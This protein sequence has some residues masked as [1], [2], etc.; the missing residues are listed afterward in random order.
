MDKIV[1]SVKN[2]SLARSSE[3][4]VP[5]KIVR[6]RELQK[7]MI[8]THISDPLM[9]GVAFWLVPSALDFL[10]SSRSHNISQILLFP[11]CITILAGDIRIPRLFCVIGRRDPIFW[12]TS[13][14]FQFVCLG[15]NS[16]SPMTTC[17]TSGDPCNNPLVYKLVPN[18]E[19]VYPNLFHRVKSQDGPKGCGVHSRGAI[20]RI[21]ADRIVYQ[22]L[23]LIRRGSFTV[24]W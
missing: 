23:N 21:S 19:G 6:S 18:P 3:K 4:I 12:L 10:S 1:P 9:L 16:W 24:N 2:C 8:I 22:L 11:G 5:S 13:E 14:S 20:A 17:N 15:C 7:T